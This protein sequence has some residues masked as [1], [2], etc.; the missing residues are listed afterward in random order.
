M[1]IMS[2]FS[3]ATHKFQVITERESA[4]GS[5]IETLPFLLACQEIIPF[6]GKKIIGKLISSSIGSRL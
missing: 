3:E 2:L 5:I 6:F 4:S 1:T